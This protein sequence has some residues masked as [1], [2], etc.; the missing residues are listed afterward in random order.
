[1]PEP[2]VLAVRR[3]PALAVW[4]VKLAADL[5]RALVREGLRRVDEFARRHNACELAW[6]VAPE[7]FLNINTPG[8]LLAAERL[9]LRRSKS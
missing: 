2:D 1:V 8:D 5:R 9:M 4:S 6:P 3:Q 7:A